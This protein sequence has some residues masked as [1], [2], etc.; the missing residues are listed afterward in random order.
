MPGSGLVTMVDH[1]RTGDLNRLYTLF[2]RVPQ[3]A[4]K[5]ALRNAIHTDVE[6]R[7]KAINESAT[8]PESGPS[9]NAEQGGMEVEGDVKGKG[10]VKPA[11]SASAALTSALRWVQ[12]VLDLKDKYDNILNQAFAGD[13]AVQTSINH[14]SPAGWSESG[15]DGN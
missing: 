11:S 10:K 15:S 1:D 3:D 7:G 8:E 14:V 4:G 2:L 12:D 6:E 5:E 9:A 13:K